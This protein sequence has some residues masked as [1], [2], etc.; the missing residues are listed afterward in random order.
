[1]ALSVGGSAQQQLEPDKTRTRVTFETVEEWYSMLVGHALTDDRGDPKLIGTVINFLE[2]IRDNVNKV[3]EDGH[4][5]KR[6][7]LQD[8]GS[9]PFTFPNLPQGF[10]LAVLKLLDYE[11]VDHLAAVFP[12]GSFDDIVVRVQLDDTPLPPHPTLRTVKVQGMGDPR[13]KKPIQLVYQQHGE[14]ADIRYSLSRA[15]KS[16]FNHFL[17]RGMKH[18]DGSRQ[19]CIGLTGIMNELI[20]SSTFTFKDCDRIYIHSVRELKPSQL[21]LEDIDELSIQH[22]TLRRSVFDLNP[23]NIERL[24]CQPDLLNHINSENVRILDIRGGRDDGLTY[25]SR[26]K[27]LNEIV[28]IFDVLDIRQLTLTRATEFTVS[29]MTHPYTV[30][31]IIAPNLVMAVFRFNKFAPVIRNIDAPKLNVVTFEEKTDQTVNLDPKF[32][33]QKQWTEFLERGGDIDFRMLKRVKLLDLG[34]FRYPLWSE[35]ENLINVRQL[36]INTVAF[37]SYAEHVSV[38]LPILTD[39]TVRLMTG[40]VKIPII[41]SDVGL[42]SLTFIEHSHMN[43]LHTHQKHILRLVRANEKLNKLSFMNHKPNSLGRFDGKAVF[44]IIAQQHKLENLEVD[45]IEVNDGFIAKLPDNIKSLTIWSGRCKRMDNHLV[46]LGGL[47]LQTL[48]LRLEFLIQYNPN[49]RKERLAMVTLK[50]FPALERADI[51][52][53]PAEFRLYGL[54]KLNRLNVGVAEWLTVGKAGALRNVECTLLQGIN[55]NAIPESWRDDKI[56]LVVHRSQLDDIVSDLHQGHVHHALQFAQ[57]H[58]DDATGDL[59]KLV[60]PGPRQL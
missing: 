23:L 13:M 39:L 5:T 47:R 45:K 12:K 60:I 55:E 59:D 24:M 26:H 3:D 40:L 48:V 34:N 44:E 56:D 43:Q 16:S 38:C 10:K 14:L 52:T 35:A 4:F 41:T 27:L 42:D 21:I 32:T 36:I 7:R 51:H 30:D 15:L 19:V 11:S 25:I 33:D 53:T 6:Q 54:K 17:L 46:L 20:S 57:A 58:V 18:G 50:D 31:D 1:M 29:G 28:N 2:R 49:K 22:C 9:R 37:E 8:H